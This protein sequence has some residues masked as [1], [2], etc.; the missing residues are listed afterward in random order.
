MAGNENNKSLFQ[1][2]T[3]V[4]HYGHQE[5]SKNHFEREYKYCFLELA[6]GT[7]RSN[8]IELLPDIFNRQACLSYWKTQKNIP[9]SPGKA[10]FIGKICRS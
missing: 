8:G 6:E 7:R 9:I 2:E 3:M 10:D 1:N 5:R 4:L